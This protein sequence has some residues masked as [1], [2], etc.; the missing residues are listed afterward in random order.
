[1]DFVTQVYFHR[2]DNIYLNKFIQIDA[3]IANDMLC[4]L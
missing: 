3:I 4:L 2:G 1:M